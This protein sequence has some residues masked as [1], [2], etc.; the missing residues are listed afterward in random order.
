MSHI[1]L[2]DSLTRVG[3]ALPSFQQWKWTIGGLGTQKESS[4]RP[5]LSL[6]WQEGWGIRATDFICIDA[7]DSSAR[8][9]GLRALVSLQWVQ[10]ASMSM[11]MTWGTIEVFW[12]TRARC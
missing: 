11:A 5:P 6:H 3:G 10:G 8:S 12:Q 1:R 9:R 2:C 4:P 7:M